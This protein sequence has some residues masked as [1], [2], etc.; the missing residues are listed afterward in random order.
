MNGPGPP[1]G[2]VFNQFHLSQNINVRVI[3]SRK[4]HFM[5]RIVSLF[6]PAALDQVMQ[7]PHPVIIP[8]VLYKHGFD[9]FVYI[10]LWVLETSQDRSYLLHTKHPH[11]CRHKASLS[12]LLK[13]AF[14]RGKASSYQRFS[15]PVHIACSLLS[16]LL[17]H[18]YIH[19]TL[20]SA[21]GDK[22]QPWCPFLTSTVKTMRMQVISW[23][24]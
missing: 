16:V 17:W 22:L 23:T 3:I 6:G 7:A 2:P 20:E 19:L 13:K 8:F 11:L 4:I 18:I 10:L 15:C 5:Q 12:S 9:V 24:I 14:W 21:R 1:D